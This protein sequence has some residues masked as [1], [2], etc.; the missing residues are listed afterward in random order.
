[1][2]LQLLARIQYKKANNLNNQILASALNNECMQPKNQANIC[3]SMHVND[4]NDN[5]LISSFLY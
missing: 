3:K 5:S 4:D 1:M 2:T